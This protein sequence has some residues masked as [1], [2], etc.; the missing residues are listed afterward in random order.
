MKRL[1][2]LSALVL[3]MFSGFNAEAQ[4]GQRRSYNQRN[5]N[6][7][8]SKDTSDKKT[9]F[10]HLTFGGNATAFFGSTTLVEIMPLV[11]YKVND[12]LQIGLGPSYAF[13]NY[14]TA[15]DNSAVPVDAY[16]IVKNNSVF[17]GRV[18]I[19]YNFY[20]NFFVRGEI[21][22]LD[23]QYGKNLALVPDPNNQGGYIAEYNLSRRFVPATLIGGGIK[24]P[25]GP[26]SFAYVSVMY[27]LTYNVLYSYYPSPI[28]LAVGFM[29]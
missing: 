28:R 16:T 1:L 18:Y 23:I 25:M 27:D 17:G 9:F 6:K 22:E 2:I 21:E 5:R 3:F 19:H 20:R 8:D 11:G 15:V 13:R 26:H 24:N 29:F 10:E 14:M 4:I 7:E 12:K